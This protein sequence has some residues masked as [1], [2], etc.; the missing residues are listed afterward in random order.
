MR[1]NRR[2]IEKTKKNGTAISPASYNTR[3][4]CGHLKSSLPSIFFKRK[5][6]QANELTEF[7]EKYPPEDDD[8]MSARISSS[9]MKFI[10]IEQQKF[11]IWTRGL[12]SPTS[13][14]AWRVARRLIKWA[15]ETWHEWIVW[16]WLSPHQG[17]SSLHDL[18]VWSSS[19]PLVSTCRVHVVDPP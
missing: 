2:Q 8:S 5:H 6:V 7:Q 13:P 10:Q 12:L 4:S 3:D 11:D 14:T 9:I 15:G 17:A 18:L 16:E 1:Q 19:S